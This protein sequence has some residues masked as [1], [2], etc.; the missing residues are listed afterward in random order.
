V[1]E[2]RG[3]PIRVAVMMLTLASGR[4]GGTEVYAE[5]LIT[6]LR[7]L[8]DN[9]FEFTVVR[10]RQGDAAKKSSR[11]FVWPGAETTD[12]SS[13]SRTVTLDFIGAGITH[14]Q[15]IRAWVTATVFRQRVW[16]E[17]ERVA[18]G[19]V[20]IAFYPFTAVQPKPPK[21]AKSVVV[22]HDLQHL[23]R[24][25]AFTAAQRVYRRIAYERPAKRC[26][27]IVTV[28]DFTSRS[29][30]E[31]LGVNQSRIH[32][33]YPGIDTDL[34][35]PG[36]R[37][38]PT[39]PALY[40]PARGLPHKNHARLFRAVERVRE[41]HQGL[42]LILSGSDEQ[43]LHPLPD[44]VVHVG[45]ITPRE[46]RD[47]YRGVTAVVFPSL[48]EGFGFP[49]LEALATGTPVVAS[50]AG[51]LPELLANHAILVDQT[52]VDSI[53]EG[54][55]KALSQ[56]GLARRAK[57]STSS[58]V[59]DFTWSKTAENVMQVFAQVGSR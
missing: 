34:F 37:N 33:V 55:E 53:A 43:S 19:P 52:D 20:D 16:R 59:A 25:H 11:R 12:A 15:K 47:L 29:V 40:Y 57:S 23:D 6:N 31:H 5:N 41:H 7:K 17:I 54:I 21:S 22:V 30:T 50:R 13:H 38:S 51:A 9:R 58:A 24:P 42:T 18:G 35:Q 49:P 2:R 32:R 27:A 39:E 56:S 48:Y 4:M 36:V 1:I 3:H 46:V 14:A 8:N 44:F 28:S 45:N 10:A 26:D